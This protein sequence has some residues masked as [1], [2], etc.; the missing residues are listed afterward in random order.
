MEYHRALKRHALASSLDSYYTMTYDT[1][2][3]SLIAQRSTRV[4]PMLRINTIATS[5][6]GATLYIWDHMVLAVH[7]FILAYGLYQIFG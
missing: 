2:H 6:C 7:R 5:S 1:T 4:A 3:L